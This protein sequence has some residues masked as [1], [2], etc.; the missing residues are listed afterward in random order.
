MRD[1]AGH[2][3]PAREAFVSVFGHRTAV[4]P[5]Q[6][7]ISGRRIVPSAPFCPQLEHLHG[8]VR[9]NT[10]RRECYGQSHVHHEPSARSTDHTPLEHS[11]PLRRRR[12]QARRR[13]R[14]VV[15]AP[16]ADARRG[17]VLRPKLLRG[18]GQRLHPDRFAVTRRRTVRMLQ[19]RSV[20]ATSGCCRCEFP[21]SACGAG[22]LACK[23]GLGDGCPVDPAL[24]I[25]RTGWCWCARRVASCEGSVSARWRRCRRRGSRRGR[26]GVPGT[27]RCAGR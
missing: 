11:L 3:L 6:D 9:R 7:R 14:S 5:G 12:T 4:L 19:Y 8:G 21:E 27:A 17:F 23:P 13:S 18:A 22:L 2:A 10:S 15:G 24:R 20:A 25:T 16:A 1:H 26:R